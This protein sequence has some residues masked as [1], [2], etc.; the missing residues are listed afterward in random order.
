[1]VQL[2]KFPSFYLGDLCLFGSKAFCCTSSFTGNNCKYIELFF[3]NIWCTNDALEGTWYGTGDF[4]HTSLNYHRLKAL[5]STSLWQYHM[6]P[7]N[8]QYFRSGRWRDWRRLLW[9]IQALLLWRL[10][11]S[12]G[13]LI[14]ESRI[15]VFD[16]FS[17]LASVEGTTSSVGK[18]TSGQFSFSL[19][20]WRSGKGGHVL[21]GQKNWSVNPSYCDPELFNW[22]FVMYLYHCALSNPWFRVL[23][24]T[25]TLIA[26]FLGSR[27]PCADLATKIPTDR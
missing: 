5:V 3:W 17:L 6:S 11:V 24:S 7:R 14:V 23:C 15:M 12:Y 19:A 4:Q 13:N 8:V 2:L 22:D 27:V 18:S 9:R 26:F 10:I 1:M 20:D 25:S 21:F 16:I